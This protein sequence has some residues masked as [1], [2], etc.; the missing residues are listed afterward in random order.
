MVK[1][2]LFH[3]FV[4]LIVVFFSCSEFEEPSSLVGRWKGTTYREYENNKLILTETFEGYFIIFKEDGTLILEIGGDIECEANY[5][6]KNMDSKPQK[7]DWC[8]GEEGLLTIKSNDLI[9]IS[10][11]YDDGFREELELIRK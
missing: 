6:S 2:K 10:F 3:V 7:I 8:D 9:V 5:S 11:E 1:I 4:L